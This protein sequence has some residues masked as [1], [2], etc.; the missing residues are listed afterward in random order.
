MELHDIRSFIHHGNMAFISHVREIIFGMQ[1]GMVSTL[2]ALTGIA[3]GTNDYFTV[4]LSGVVIIAVESI[5]MS[6]GSFTSSA[7]NGI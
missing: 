4:I 1:D 7:S 3:V 2:G 5:S 6:I